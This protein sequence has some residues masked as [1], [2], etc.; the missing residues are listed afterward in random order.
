MQINLFTENDSDD[1]DGD[2][3]CGGSGECVS[4]LLV[5]VAV[6]AEDDIVLSVR[7]SKQ[8]VN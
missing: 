7:R 5:A 1:N 3:D 4:S 8:F 6:F 2:G